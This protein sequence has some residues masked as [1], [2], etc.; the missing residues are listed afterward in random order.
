MTTRK[1]IALTIQAFVGKVISLLFNT[2]SGS[3]IAFLP[4]RKYILSSW[5]QSV[6]T[7]FVFN[8]Q[9]YVYMIFIKFD[10]YICMHM[11]TFFICNHLFLCFLTKSWFSF[12]SVYKQFHNTYSFYAPQLFNL[13]IFKLKNFNP[14]Q[15]VWE[16]T[17][18]RLI[19]CSLPHFIFSL[20]LYKYIIYNHIYKSIHFKNSVD[21]VPFLRNPFFL[22]PLQLRL[23]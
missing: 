21:M 22:C 17:L 18:S 2:L 13:K 5:L 3:V 16:Y 1:T 15:K 6:S 10:H 8:M 12:M 11:Y 7:V 4:R 20:A 14:S 9:I 19:N 23:R